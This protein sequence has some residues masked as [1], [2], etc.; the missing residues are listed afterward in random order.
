[1]NKTLECFWKSFT[2]IYSNTAIVDK[3]F[4]FMAAN[5]PNGSDKKINKEDLKEFN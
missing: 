1:M 4:D 3:L 5:Y 2:G